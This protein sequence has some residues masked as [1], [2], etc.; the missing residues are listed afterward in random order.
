MDILSQRHELIVLN[1]VTIVDPNAGN[2]RV[3]GGDAV[4]KVAAT[5]LRNS[6]D[7]YHP[8]LQYLALLQELVDKAEGDVREDRTGVGTYSVFGRQMRFN[9]NKGFPLLTTKKIFTK[10]VFG[11]LAW[12]LRGD[13]NVRWLQERGIKIW[14]EW[15]DE[16][17]ELG[18]VYGKQWRAWETLNPEMLE[19]DEVGDLIEIDQIEQAIKLLKDNPTSRRNV[20]SAWNVGELD[21]MRLNPCHVLFQLY[22][23]DGKLDLQLY[24]RSADIFLGVPFNMAS[25]SALVHLIADE[26]GLEPGTFI[27]TFGDLHLYAN[28]VAQAKEQLSRTP[29]AWPTLSI[30]DGAKIYELEPSDFAVE[31]YD[32]HPAIKAEVAV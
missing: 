21:Q 10:A 18:P 9:L 7:P 5:M 30:K 8:E 32:P 14:D 13:T 3:A 25:Y 16:N 19:D 4:L 29:K 23:D 31:G 26:V 28:H 20:V 12:F 6:D 2:M 24:Q 15:A 11:E 17:G 22:V 1:G 27:H